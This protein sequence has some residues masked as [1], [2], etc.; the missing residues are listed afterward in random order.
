MSGCYCTQKKAQNRITH[1]S[2][3]IIAQHQTSSG[4]DT[5]RLARVPQTASTL[6]LQLAALIGPVSQMVLQP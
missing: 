6:E 1:D 3:S 4:S 2:Y 5:T